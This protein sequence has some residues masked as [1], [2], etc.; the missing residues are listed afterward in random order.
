MRERSESSNYRGAGQLTTTGPLAINADD[1]DRTEVRRAFRRATN[2]LPWA[3]N[4]PS[5]RSATKPWVRVYR[6]RLMWSDVVTVVGAILLAYFMRFGPED[7]LDAKSRVAVPVIAVSVALAAAWLLALPAAQAYDRRILGSGTDEYSRALMASMWVFG[8]LAILDLIFRLNIARGFIL[9]ALPIGTVS[10]VLT[11]WIWRQV[12][13]HAREN[14]RHLERIL[15]VGTCSSSLPL[16]KRLV[17]NPRFGYEVVGLCLPPADRTQGETVVAD[18]RTIPVFRE[19]EDLTSIVLKQHADAVAVTS[20]AAL[21]DDA[22]RELSWSLEGY[23]VDVLVAPGATDVA[24]PRMMMRQVDGLPL[25]HIDKPRYGAAKNLGKT[26][27]DY[28]VALTA[29][30]RPSQFSVLLRCGGLWILHAPIAF[31]R[32][33]ASRP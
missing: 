25:L 20:S 6:R 22:L 7:A 11:R 2:V 29:R 1:V 19:D 26:V 30:T 32:Y 17:K 3:A 21:G 13:G 12:L 8:L 16:V 14:A 27:L 5:R 18:K 10:L 28:A 24:G 4:T 31:H 23:N 15:I 9:L 33:G